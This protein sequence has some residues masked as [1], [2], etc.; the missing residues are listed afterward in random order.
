MPAMA[1]SNPVSDTSRSIQHNPDE[2]W[3]SE[4]QLRVVWYNNIGQPAIR[5]EQISANQFFGHGQYG[6]PLPGEYLIQAI[7]RMR[8]MGP[9]KIK[10]GP[11]ANGRTKAK[12]A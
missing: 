4:V 6:A 9:P 2:T 10:R 12:K 8:K 7:E 1:I 5:T 3:P 11:T